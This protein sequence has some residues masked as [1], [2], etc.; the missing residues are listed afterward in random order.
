MSGSQRSSSDATLTGTTTGSTNSKMSKGIWIEKLAI[1][2]KF[3]QK[4]ADAADP[5][6]LIYQECKQVLEFVHRKESFRRQLRQRCPQ[7]DFCLYSDSILMQK[8]QQFG[9]G[10]LVDAENIRQRRAIY[11]QTHLIVLVHGLEGLGRDK[12]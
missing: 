8:H 3:P 12:L 2:N 5:E 4:K 11:E 7:H 1:M 6:S 10:S 9:G